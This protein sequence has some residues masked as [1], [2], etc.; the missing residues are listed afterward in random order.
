MTWAIIKP[1][2]IGSCSQRLAK[3][4]CAKMTIRS[5]AVRLVGV[6]CSIKCVV[7]RKDKG[8]HF[9]RKVFKLQFEWLNL[10]RKAV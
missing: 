2:Y 7:C 10:K 3:M 6:E 8:R 5:W 4:K 1:I 9:N